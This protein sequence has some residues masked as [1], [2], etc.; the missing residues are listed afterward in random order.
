MWPKYS[1]MDEA[2]GETGGAGGGDAG[3]GDAGAPK[4]D[5]QVELLT[6]SVG[7]LTQGLQQLSEQQ[8]QIA[9]SLETFSKSATPPKDETP[10]DDNIFNDVDL[11]QLDRK[12][13]IGLI[14]KSITT[15]MQKTLGGITNDVDTKINNLAE[16][17]EQKNAGEAVQR[18]AEANPD[19]WEWSTE[20]KQLLKENP[21]LTVSRAYNLAKSEAPKKVEELGKKYL[22]EEQGSTKVNRDF[23]LMGLTPTSSRSSG[24]KNSKMTFQQASEKA[25]EK[26]MDDLD[27]VLRSGGKVA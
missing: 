22:K 8:A 24:E 3:D 1:L 4:A 11:E 10:P 20:I 19:F 12:Q 23:G 14:T 9:A 15:E 17:F 5:P 21:T 27:E 18:A 13:L 16:R 7:L 26:V 2:G 6:K 25:Y